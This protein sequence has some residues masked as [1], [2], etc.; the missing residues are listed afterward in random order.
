MK[1]KFIVGKNG[2]VSVVKI[3]A[4]I[5]G[6]ALRLRIKRAEEKIGMPLYRRDAASST[7]IV[8]G[9]TILFTD[10]AACEKFAARHR[11]GDLKSRSTTR[12]VCQSRASKWLHRKA[13]EAGI[14]GKYINDYRPGWL[15]DLRKTVRIPEIALKLAYGV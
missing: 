2:L 14:F 1:S 10:Y 13:V 9:E 3:P 11:L 4:E 12:R 7:K 5:E 6:D 8:S 15:Q